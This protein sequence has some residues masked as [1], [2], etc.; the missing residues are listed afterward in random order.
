MRRRRTNENEVAIT[1][2]AAEDQRMEMRMRDAKELPWGEGGGMPKVAVYMEG[3]LIAV[4][5]E[6]WRGGGG[7]GGGSDSCGETSDEEGPKRT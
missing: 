4:A 3:R 2:V 5:S 7:G 1:M 6:E